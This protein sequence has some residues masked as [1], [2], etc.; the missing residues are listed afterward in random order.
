MSSE[1]FDTPSVN[2]DE[3]DYLSD[4]ESTYDFEAEEREEFSEDQLEQTELFEQEVG[5]LTDDQ[6]DDPIRI[7]L[8]Q[9][10]ELPMLNREEELIV[11]R[12]VEQR[13]DR[14]F[15]YLVSNDYLLRSSVEILEK[16]HRGELR[17]DRT[18][19][20]SVTNEETKNRFAK[21]LEP[22]L[23]TLRNLLQRSESNFKIAFCK[24]ASM[25]KRHAAWRKM[26]AIRFKAAR[27][28]LETGLR[29]ERL[30]QP[31]KEFNEICEKVEYLR[32]QIQNCKGKPEKAAF[33]RSMREELQYFIGQT[34][35]SPATMA[36]RVQKIKMYLEKYEEAK[37]RLSSGN[38]R[39]VVSIAKHYRNR[40]LSF[41]DLIQEGNTGLMR[42]V[43]KFESI[44]G[45]KFSTYATWWIRQAITR[46]TA[47]YGRTIRIPIHMVDTI[48]KVRQA[49]RELQKENHAD[50]T[51]EETA[52]RAGVDARLVFN[53]IQMCRAPLSLNQPVGDNEDSYYGEFLCDRRNTDPF[54]TVNNVALRER[55]N[56][57]LEDLTYRER[58]IIRLR[59]GLL[60]GYAYTLEEVGQIF[61]VTRERVRQIEA[62]AVRKLQ[63]PIRSRRLSSFVQRGSEDPVEALVKKKKNRKK[64]IANQQSSPEPV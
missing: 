21:I 12:R 47:D 13:R 17:L 35:E 3:I 15:C 49:R 6:L 54:E 24:S 56:S 4:P 8:L 39:L 44:R 37:R 20:V 32:T 26:V 43:D 30:E 59:Y 62:K 51:I 9:M 50:P 57:V 18:L 64:R 60:D 33:M 38:L 10:G 52:Q 40:G 29:I 14:Y 45:Y 46:A 23:V 34:H 5:I 58:E 61:A 63:H 41:L 22:N 16:V 2:Y 28:I 31:I 19:E 55:I 1:T 48:R 27:L 25:V 53:I 11:A 36:R 42:A 7:Y